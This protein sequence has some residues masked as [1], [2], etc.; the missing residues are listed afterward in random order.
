[1]PKEVTKDETLLEIPDA[2]ADHFELDAATYEEGALKVQAS[3]GIPMSSVI[4]PDAAAILQM[5]AE[6]DDDHVFT[7]SEVKGILFKLGLAVAK[8]YGLGKFLS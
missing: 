5:V 1:M 8:H 4:G 6:A 2:V 7:K 3:F